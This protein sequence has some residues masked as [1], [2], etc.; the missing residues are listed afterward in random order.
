MGGFSC[1]MHNVFSINGG[2]AVDDL[3]TTSK[4]YAFPENELQRTKERAWILR[5]AKRDSIGAEIGIFSG[6]FSGELSRAH[7]VGTSATHL[8]QTASSCLHAHACL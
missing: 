7:I 8:F 5:F 2:A 3:E 1:D 6:H 4:Q